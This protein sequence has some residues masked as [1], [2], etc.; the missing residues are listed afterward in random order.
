MEKPSTLRA[1]N[2][3]LGTVF[4]AVRFR[5]SERN[6]SELISTV[7]VNTRTGRIRGVDAHSDK[8]KCIVIPTEQVRSQLVKGLLYDVALT[9]MSNGKVGYVAIDAAPHM[10]KATVRSIYEPRRVY[11]VKVEFG[12]KTFI[13]DPLEGKQPH[14]NTIEG[15]LEALG[16]R[17]DIYRLPAILAEAECQARIILHYFDKEDQR[18]IHEVR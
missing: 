15:F 10:F 5:P 6:K 2:Y 7:S 16:R 9:P 12:A 17:L 3:P 18:N 8:L 1:T 4:A 14:T 11:Q 13:Y